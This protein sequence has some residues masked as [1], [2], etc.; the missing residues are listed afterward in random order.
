MGRVGGGGELAPPEEAAPSFERMAKAAAGM[1]LKIYLDP[2]SAFHQVGVDPL[3]GAPSPLIVPPPWSC[4]PRAPLTSAT[5]STRCSAGV[6]RRA[7][8]HCAPT[9]SHGAS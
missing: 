9:S 5:F 2:S 6:R 1:R 7:W 3:Y 4:P 8:P